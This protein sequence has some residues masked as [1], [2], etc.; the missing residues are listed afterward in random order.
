[1]F[2][3]TDCA[4]ETVDVVERLGAQA[5]HNG[6]TGEYAEECNA[7]DNVVKKKVRLD[8]NSK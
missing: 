1:L 4:K 5:V 8:V 7:N 3:I 6:G 2:R